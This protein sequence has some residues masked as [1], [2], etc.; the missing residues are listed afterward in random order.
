M[1]R[2]AR[3][4]GQPRIT[5]HR[6][7]SGFQRNASPRTVNGLLLRTAL[8]STTRGADVPL[9]RLPCTCTPAARPRTTPAHPPCTSL[10]TTRTCAALSS[11]STAE[12]WLL[13]IRF[14]STVADAPSFT[15]TPTWLPTSTFDRTA[16]P[17]PPSTSM[18]LPPLPVATLPTN[19]LPLDASKRVG[20]SVRPSSIMNPWPR[21]P[22]DTL[23]LSTFLSHPRE[24]MN[25][26]R[27]LP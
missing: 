10:P 2:A 3:S 25:P 4:T 23:W 16:L 22:R 14:C 12:R 26:C 5:V 19:R 13:L 1:L 6:I 17:V 8:P 18:P 9:S 24:K 11:T 7:S 21:L 15:R 20:S 27:P